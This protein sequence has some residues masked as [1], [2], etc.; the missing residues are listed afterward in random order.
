MYSRSHF[1]STVHELL[2]VTEGSAELCFGGENNPK[3]VETEVSRGDVMIIP[4]GVAHRLLKEGDGNSGFSMVGSY[5]KGKSWDMCYG[6]E[7]E[8][9]KVEGIKNVMW[10]RKDPIYGDEGPA[11]QN[12]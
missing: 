12:N 5:E 9:Q 10:W 7:G 8:E 11:V 4:A 1:H 6:I 2:V 3:R